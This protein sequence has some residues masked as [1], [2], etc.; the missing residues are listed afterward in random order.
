M[1]ELLQT[2]NLA[3]GYVYKGDQCAQYVFHNTPKNIAYFLGSRPMA[4]KMV[5][6]DALDRLILDTV[7]NFIDQ[8]PDQELLT[9]IKKALT[10]IQT[11]EAEAKPLFCPTMDEV[12]EYC[13]QQ[14]LEDDL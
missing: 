4:T 2:N 3:C 12:D 7:G 6:T 9:E 14:L 10:P 5:V 8:C 13:D 1:A 11:G